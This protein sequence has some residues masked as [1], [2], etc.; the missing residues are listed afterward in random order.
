LNS[1][2]TKMIKTDSHVRLVSMNSVAH[3]EYK[4]DKSLI[5]YR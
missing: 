4:G 2:V 3:L 1:S 5:S